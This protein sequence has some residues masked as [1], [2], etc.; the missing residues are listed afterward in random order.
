MKKLQT[1]AQAVL[2]PLALWMSAYS[3]NLRAEDIDIYVDNA[4]TAGA[5]NVLFIM[6]NSSNV[7]S[8]WNG[9]GC[10][11]YTGTTEAPSL[12][13]NTAGGVIQCALVD[14][15]NSLPNGALN[16]GLMVGN[17]NGFA[18][19]VR[20]SSDSS[21][22]E[23]CQ[24]SEGGCLLR[25]LTLM[26][27]TNKQSLSKFI[28][29]WKASNSNADAESFPVRVNSAASGQMMQEAWA[30]Y[31]GQRG[32]SGKTYAPSLLQGCQKNFVI[33]IGN[34]DKTPA[35]D[36]L[37]G[38]ALAGAGATTEQRSRIMES[39]TF[40][41]AI[42]GPKNIRSVPAAGNANDWSANWADEWSNLM[43]VQDR[44]TSTQEGM[45]NIITYTVGIIDNN[46]NQCT[47]DYPALLSKMAEKGGGKSFRVSNVSEMTTALLH[48]LNEV[49]AVN[50][51]FSSASLPVSVNAEGSYLN[52]IFLGMFR[53]DAT[54]APRWLGNLKQYQLIRN[55]SG[56][57]VMGD[58]EGK[59]AISSGGTGFLAPDAVSFWTYKDS[60]TLPDSAGG[61]FINDKKG[62]PVHAFDRAD[63]EVVEKGGVAQQ[64]RKQNLQA[65]FTGEGGTTDN[66][67]KVYTFCPHGGTDADP[68]QK[69]LA[70]ADNDFATSN[71]K[72]AAAT[73]GAAVTVP[74]L[75]IVRT[76]S[77]AL[78][79]TS[80][81]HGFTD[82]SIVTIR[83]ATQ[84]EY[85]KTQAVTRISATQ[86][87]I[88]GLPDYPR[89]PSSI[90]Y[91]VSVPGAVGTFGIASLSRATSS[92]GSAR[93]LVTVTTTADH[94]YLAGQT[95][96]ISGV[97]PSDF[98]GNWSIETVPTAKTFTFYIPIYP[99]SPALNTYDVVHVPTSWSISTISPSGSIAQ[100]GTSINHSVRAG[101]TIRIA[102][103]NGNGKADYNGE[104][105]VLEVT[106]LKNFTIAKPS[107]GGSVGA[108]G[109]VSLSQAAK[110]AAAVTRTTTSTATTAMVSGMPSNWFGN[111][112]K[113]EIR[114]TGSSPN[115]TAYSV[116]QA[117]ITC[118]GGCE[119]FTYAIAASP[120]IAASSVGTVS[121][122][123]AGATA[124][125]AVGDIT[126]A[127]D[128]ATVR[129]VPANRFL[130]G[131]VV[132]I[133]ATTGSAPSTEAAYVGS[134]QISCGADASCASFT[135][136][137]VTLT[138]TSPATGT[139]I[140]AYSTNTAPD[141][142]LM[143]KWLRGQDNHGDEKG[144]G[145]G[146]TV[147]P[148]MHGDVLHS[149]PLVINYGDSRG[150]VVFYGSNDGVYRAING[151]S[152]GT[153]NGV[154]AGGEL[155][156]LI[157]P[158]HYQLINRYRSNAPEVKFPMS[159][160]PSAQPKDYFVD[161]PTGVY[162]RLNADGSIAKAYIYLTMRRGGRFIYALDVT[163]PNAPK[164]LWSISQQTPG[165]EELG[166]TWSRPRLTLLQNLKGGTPA[167]PTPVVVF[168]AGYDQAQDAEPPTGDTMGRGIFVVNAE[169]GALVWSASPSCNAAL[170][171]CKKVDG[172]KYATPSDITF[173]DRDLDGFTD[174][175]YWG[176]LGG[177]VWRAD[178]ADADITGWK[179]T[180]LAQLGCDTGECASGATPRKFFFPPA[181]LSVR[182][183]G[184][185]D[186]YEAISVVSGDR[187]HPLRSAAAGSS[188]LVQDKFFMI[189]DQGTT[190]GAPVG[191]PSTSDVT[192][193]SAH[194]FNAT[195]TL[196]DGSLKGFYIAL[197]GNTT[198]GDRGEKGV[199][200]PVAVNGQIFFSTNRPTPR[201]VNTCAANLGEAK[202]YAVS[203]FTG[204]SASNVL[205][206]GGLPPSAVSGLIL[207]TEEDDKGN[208]VTRREKFC[209][210][211]G[212]S[213]SQVGG[214]NKA[215][216]TSALE[217]C[218]V[219]TIIPKNLKRT[220]WYKK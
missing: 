145:S 71:T 209:I 88:S 17:S 112:D 55:S 135:F 64:L 96:N 126:R 148:S 172:M 70:H 31:N 207:I 141:K 158:E 41:P 206:G 94:P 138:P 110:R 182:Q 131:S 99:V 34:T 79:T 174:K 152:S 13:T 180:R 46:A 92:S 137:P 116:G 45:Q 73:F 120:A 98:N 56:Q 10:S 165:F 84:P 69:D 134:W 193:S 178:V 171:P 208:T 60:A 118:S 139:N 27:S 23:T 202:A 74:V 203:P 168:G 28:K 90:G 63:G 183:A 82:A 176:D 160:L 154:A 121:I 117:V 6:D 140:Q 114:V 175:F 214:T 167:V 86:F 87:R 44:G 11:A 95:V 213:G 108:S 179:A 103:L 194:L 124:N 83:N 157:L 100:V 77:T 67:R 1:I 53:P 42:C 119:T 48:A 201:D 210:G 66:P 15:I 191:S 109:N 122:P 85:N 130:N 5:P 51:V 33:Y 43:F 93:E 199:N 20:S 16:V 76:G 22:H 101:Q 54:G 217:N 24:G 21:Y 57:L 166:Q 72:I 198:T 142:D 173:A 204:R 170:H 136:G 4:V 186:S 36:D 89:S 14:A 196:Y 192:A 9:G 62:T 128:T 219:G 218:N 40:T 111:G 29:S 19:D 177:N 144:P 105:V 143:I 190:V 26:D 155:W 220:Y 125:I 49:Q 91:T 200:A 162:Q 78:V 150:I 197:Q 2:V 115:E 32:L 187:E 102:G 8:T 189:K 215:P 12:G 163:Q 59:P 205:T 25:K 146:V 65:T 50:S 107:G 3:A 211:C 30:Y 52:Q 37:S 153:T 7:A 97:S 188:Y 149:R 104:H 75:S 61:F 81:S 151:N 68:C 113:V 212:I 35:N 181:V 184:A 58:Q 38:S 216:C 127:G 185:L 133:S 161:G 106:G 39:V 169:T 156:G 123:G 129:N 147:R 18:A 195:S 47:A 132:N 159:L 80:G 164:Y